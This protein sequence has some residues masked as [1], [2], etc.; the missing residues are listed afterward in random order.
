MKTKNMTTLH[1]RKSIGRSLSWRCAF[2]F[3]PLALVCFG[4]SPTAKALLP[5]PPPDGGYTGANT[6][7][8]T[9]ALFSLTSGVDN[10]AVGFQALYHNTTGSNN[11]AA[12]FRALFSNTTG[13]NNT[14]DGFQALYDNTTINGV[15]GSNNTAEGFRALFSNT[16][17]AQ[18][19]ATGVQ[20]LYHNTIG[21]F[22]TSNGYNALFQNVNGNYN[23]AYGSAS[24]LN[25][26]GGGQNVAIGAGALQSNTS[27][28]GNVA[29]GYQA[30]FRNDGAWYNTGYGYQAL[31]SNIAGVANAAVGWKALMSNI[32]DHNTAVGSEALSSN[33]TGPH[34]TA[35][36]RQALLRNTSGYFNTAIGVNALQSNTTGAFNI[37][38]GEFA[39]S[40]ITT[41]SNNIDIGH[42]GFAG[43]Q[44]TIRIGSGE[45]ILATF[46][47]GIYEVNQGSPSVPVYIS[48]GGRLGTVPP[49]SSRRFKKEI[50]PMD[51]VSEAIRGLK[52]VT[53]RYKSDTTDT[54]QFGLI[55]EEVAAV[56]PDLVVRDKNGEIY[57]VRY[58]AVNVMLLNE[59]LKEH[60]KVENLK[61]DF[62]ATVAQQQKEIAALTAIVKEQAAQIQKVSA[63]LAAA[64]PSR[65]GLEASKFAIGRIRGGGPA[66]Q[67]V[68]NP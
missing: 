4:L 19:T 2:V 48:S 42:G 49:S 15:A 20:A 18:N 46:I 24:L 39:G 68:N 47:D 27:G 6:A 26:Y 7:E 57:S 55:A 1:F 14:A 21:S 12:G 13:N 33:T 51:K 17:G 30:L 54:P 45:A 50:Q 41:G 5:P 23:T 38:L 37:A 65:G 63:Q 36:G 66:P 8:G 34:N 11:T 40:N 52:P 32:S 31:Y 9:N 56:N 67:V 28:N 53:F 58:D 29:T 25:N 62:Q 35:V 16:T 3:V 60:R 43:D 44:N 22:N 59:F 64:S 61:N 10:N